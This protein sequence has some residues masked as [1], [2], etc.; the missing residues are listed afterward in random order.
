MLEKVPSPMID[1]ETGK[2]GIYTLKDRLRFDNR[3]IN[4]VV[5]AG[6]LGVS[7]DLAALVKAAPDVCSWKPGGF[8]GLK[9]S[10]R[11]K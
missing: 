1:T 3:A 5:A 6:N 9:F 8:P 10:V 2:V 4:N 7:V 11:I